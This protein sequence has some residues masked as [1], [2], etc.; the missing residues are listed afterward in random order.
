MR[1]LRHYENSTKKSL[2][3]LP[4][5]PTKTRTTGDLIA[6]NF[7]LGSGILVNLLLYFEPRL[8]G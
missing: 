8:N 7:N 2:L 5:P 1:V 3:D 4:A 6:F